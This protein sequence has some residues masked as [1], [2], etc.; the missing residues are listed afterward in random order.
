M[1]N[2]GDC[3]HAGVL[4]AHA[5]QQKGSEGPCS[6]AETAAGVWEATMRD[7]CVMW[8]SL[9]QLLLAGAVQRLADTRLQ[10]ASLH[11]RS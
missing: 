5:T 2:S 7:L 4:A 6:G 1:H 10:G 3:G 8:P 9:C 11:L